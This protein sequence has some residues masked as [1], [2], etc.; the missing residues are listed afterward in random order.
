VLRALTK[1]GNVLPAFV[2]LF[3]LFNQAV[4]SAFPPTL[5]TVGLV[6]INSVAMALF[7]LRRDASKVGGKIEGLI[8]V[9]GTFSISLLQD[10]GQLKDADL[11]P[12]AI[13]LAGLAGWAVSLVALGR[14]FGVVPADR[15]L[16]RHGP[17][18]YVRHP[19]YAFEA[20]FFLGYLLAAPTDTS[21]LFGSSIAVP[22]AIIIALW[23]A[24]Q[25]VRIM[26]E[27]RIIAGYGEYRNAVRWR[28]LPGVW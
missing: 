6:L 18:K 15:G 7:M 9:V 11:L 27:E 17:Y 3:L 19:V 14:S 25:V 24:L 21:G 26:R 28:I 16:V 12:T 13:Q 10:A 1:P 5:S 22:N 2:W 4:N 8:A 23:G 20:L